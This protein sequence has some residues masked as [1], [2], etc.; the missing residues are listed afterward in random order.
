MHIYISRIYTYM[1]EIYDEE[2]APMIMEAQ[3]SRDLQLAS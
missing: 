2:L 3:K 1:Y